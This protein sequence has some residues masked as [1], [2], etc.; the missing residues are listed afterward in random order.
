MMKRGIEKIEPDKSQHIKLYC[1]DGDIEIYYDGKDLRP[2]I[3]IGDDEMYVPAHYIKS[4]FV[5]DCEPLPFPRVPSHQE[6]IEINESQSN[7]IK[8]QREEIE[9]LKQELR[10][11]NSLI[12]SMEHSDYIHI[13][14]I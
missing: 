5:N 2:R 14:R 9:R 3:V 10:Q 13:E 7:V 11:N 4:F 12:H 6:L 1:E 8:K